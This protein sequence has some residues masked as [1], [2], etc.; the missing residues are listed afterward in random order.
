MKLLDRDLKVNHRFALSDQGEMQDTS[1]LTTTV[2]RVE[3]SDKAKH[4]RIS[5]LIKR[6][7]LETDEIFDVGE[8]RMRRSVLT[9]EAS[10]RLEL[11]RIS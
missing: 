10:G 5:R 4:K 7:G 9:L 1:M 6:F 11:P 2:I 8:W 3:I